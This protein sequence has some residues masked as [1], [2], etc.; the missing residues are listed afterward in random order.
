MASAEPD[1]IGPDDLAAAELALG[2]LDGEARTAALARVAADPAFALAVA[3]WEA[4]FAALFADGADVAVPPAVLRRIEASLDGMGRDDGRR[5]PAANDNPGVGLWRGT[6]IAAG[7]AA[8]LLLVVTVMLALRPAP[9]PVRVPV[10]VAAQAPLL[11]A[12]A[13]SEGKGAPIAAA[14]DR[15]TGVV[16]IGGAV[17]VPAGRSA[18][19][20]AI[21]GSAAPRALGVMAAGRVVVPAGLRAEMAADTVLAISIEPAGGSPTGLPTGPVVAAG[22]L[23]G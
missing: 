17:A 1:D 15:E 14:Y 4:R 9:E 11:A 23:A 16:R 2:L 10:P 5:A 20:W 13:P 7:L 21:R 18:E 8:C 12:L 22:K 3:W 19:L 6:A